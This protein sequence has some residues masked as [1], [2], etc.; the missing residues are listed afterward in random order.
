MVEKD[1]LP[2]H[3]LGTDLRSSWLQVPR[4]GAPSQGGTVAIV[5]LRPPTNAFQHFPQLKRLW[6][7]GFYF[8][9]RLDMKPS[10]YGVRRCKFEAVHIS[11]VMK[12]NMHSV[13]GRM[14]MGHSKVSQ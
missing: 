10:T 13:S 4:V 6:A 12:R 5:D 11:S 3:L 8:D 1:L 9:V 7:A 14:D 2:G